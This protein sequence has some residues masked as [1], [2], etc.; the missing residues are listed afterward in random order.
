MRYA[1]DVRGW[2]EGDPLTLTTDDARDVF[3]GVMQ[4]WI[5]QRA[6]M[7][8]EDE[9]ELVTHL[10]DAGGEPLDGEFADRGMAATL[11]WM[12]ERSQVADLDIDAMD[13]VIWAMLWPI[14]E[15]LGYDES[16]R[17]L[18]FLDDEL[19]AVQQ[20]EV[21]TARDYGSSRYRSQAYDEVLSGGE[22]TATRVE[23][24]AIVLREE[25]DDVLRASV[26]RRLA[27]SVPNAWLLQSRD[28]FEPFLD[29]Q[30]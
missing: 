27:G 4:R 11:M 16:F 7:I 8:D 25:E 23:D 3:R 6:T 30:G 12:K 5:D 24:F 14:E 20:D 2:P 21:S 28:V 10:L 26:A 13:S 9:M 22:W 19:I 18:G 29:E 1:R 17:R 15:R